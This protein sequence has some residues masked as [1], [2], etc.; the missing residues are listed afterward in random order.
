MLIHNGVSQIYL[1]PIHRLGL[2]NILHIVVGDCGGQAGGEG[3]GGG[4]LPDDRH[5]GAGQGEGGEKVHHQYKAGG[6]RG[7]GPKGSGEA[8]EH[9]GAP[10]ASPGALHTVLQLL[11]RRGQ[12]VH[13]GLKFYSSIFHLTTS[14]YSSVSSSRSRDRAFFCRVETVPRGMS[15]ACAV[16]SRVRPV[17]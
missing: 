13:H 16:S 1:Y 7:N 4:Q 2:P 9:P 12:F 11:G 8:A 17:K 5:T 15:R 10:G 3:N 14:F 6:D